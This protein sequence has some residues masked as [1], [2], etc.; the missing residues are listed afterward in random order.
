MDDKMKAIIGEWLSSIGWDFFPESI[1]KFVPHL[2][3]CFNNG[4]NYVDKPH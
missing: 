1:K 3:K 2:D 4:G